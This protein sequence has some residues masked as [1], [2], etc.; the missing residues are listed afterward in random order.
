[1]VNKTDILSYFG[2][3][4]RAFFERYGIRFL[5]RKTQTAVRCLWHDDE[6]PSLSI[7]TAEGTFCCHAGCDAGNVFDFYARVKGLSVHAD[8]PEVLHGIA[9]D[10]GIGGNSAVEAPA[11]RADG[12]GNNLLPIH[13]LSA[14]LRAWLA[15]H[16]KAYGDATLGHFGIGVS[17]YRG[18]PCLVVPINDRLQK[19]YFWRRENKQKRWQHHPCGKGWLYD[20]NEACEEVILCEGEWDFLTLYDRGYRGLATGTTGAGHLPQG[21]A[22]RFQGK[23]VTIVYDRDQAGREGAKKAAKVLHGV[24]R[25]IGIAE[26]PEAVGEHGDVSDYFQK[27]GGATADF[28][29]DVLR[30]AKPY[31]PEKEAQAEL[32]TALEAAQNRRLVHPAQDFVQGVMY[33]A[34]AKIERPK[35]AGKP[36]ELY[37]LT[38]ER[39]LLTRSHGRATGLVFLHEDVQRPA[40]SKTG[41]EGFLQGSGGVSPAVL[42][43]ELQAYILAFIVLKEPAYG[44]FLALWTM[45]TY[46]HRIFRYYPY[47]WLNSLVK[48]S[49]KT[50]LMEI[51][52]PVVFNGMLVV[53]PSPAIMY[54]YVSENAPTF[55]IDE[56]EKMRRAD[57]ERHGEIMAILNAGFNRN[58]TVMRCEPAGG[59]K[60][61]WVAYSTYCPKMFAGLSELDDLLRDRTIRL[62]MIKKAGEPVEPY[63]ETEAIEALQQALRDKLYTVGLNYAK[64]M[65]AYYR[66]S[67]LEIVDHLSNRERDIWWPI[68]VLARLVDTD[69]GAEAVT[70]EMVDL[71]R[72]LSQLKQQEDTAVSETLQLLMTWK[73]MMDQKTPERFP[74]DATAMFYRCEAALTFFQGTEAFAWMPHLRTLTR[75]LGRLQIRVERRRVEGQVERFYRVEPLPF[76]DLYRRLVGEPK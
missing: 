27:L 21:L 20:E 55:M 44:S 30:T 64:T 76:A 69:A 14:E 45:G 28:D 53:S 52:Q 33:Y 47:V 1:M 39:R 60:F 43:R 62:D 61:R 34:V 65:A 42:H 63:H 6:H 24:A 23:D 8:F 51:L 3:D 31:E 29:E 72:R 25:S 2:R 66:N 10:F 38:S 46:V 58:G 48:G 13:P 12:S 71:S 26:L 50:L 57:R 49:G 41:I 11:T 37:L 32:M 17:E 15:A 68:L 4:F 22:E 9:A 7:N 19:L 40:L 74:D 73:E 18:E 59:G 70:R 54:R 35:E 16:G 36:P 67:A 5:D 75:R 56:M